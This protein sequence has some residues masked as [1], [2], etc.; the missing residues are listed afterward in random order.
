[1]MFCILHIKIGEAS[2]LCLLISSVIL[3]ILVQFVFL[4]EIYD[5]ITKCH[6]D[7]CVV[8]LCIGT[9]K[10]SYKVFINTLCIYCLCVA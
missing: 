2:F 7:H 1:M 8:S 10:Q 6:M 3:G 4:C 5:E 9:S